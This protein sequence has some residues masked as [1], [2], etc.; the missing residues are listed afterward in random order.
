MHENLEELKNMRRIGAL[1][2]IIGCVVD[3][4]SYPRSN[5]INNFA[6]FNI[7]EQFMAAFRYHPHCFIV[8][9]YQEDQCRRDK[10]K[11]LHSSVFKETLSS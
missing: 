1:I 10:E 2:T 9:S 4:H 3:S 6:S 7:M 8:S 5:H 11:A